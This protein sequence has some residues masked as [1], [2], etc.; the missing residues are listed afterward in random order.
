MPQLDRLI[1]FPQIFWLLF[2]FTFIYAVL[3]HF[4]LPLFI[5]SLKSRKLIEEM[6]S[7]EII[8]L[9]NQFEKN[10]SSLKQL[11]IENLSLAENLLAQTFLSS[12][13]GGEN[14]KINQANLRLNSAITNFVL[15]NNY[16]LLKSICF[17]SKIR[18]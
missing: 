18:M 11:V 14:I 8:I 7:L 4:F 3:T 1:V 13:T 10:R 5:K 16:P 12:S 17:Y 6:N 9:T 15:Y 2:F